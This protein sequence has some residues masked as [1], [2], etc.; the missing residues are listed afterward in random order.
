MQ[1]HK[2]HIQSCLRQIPQLETKDK[3]SRKQNDNAW[4]IRKVKLGT[5]V[6]EMRNYSIK[7]SAQHVKSYTASQL[8]TERSGPPQGSWNVSLNNL[9]VNI[10][11]ITM[12]V[13]RIFWKIKLAIRKTTQGTQGHIIA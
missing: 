8:V 9:L 10:L 3:D 4:E 13:T 7:V 12:H 5:Q 6:W 1:S 2:G 11:H